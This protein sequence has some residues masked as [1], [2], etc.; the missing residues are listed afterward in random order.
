MRGKNTCPLLNDGLENYGECHGVQVNG[1]G[2]ISLVKGICNQ[3]GV[4][5]L[6]WVPELAICATI[7]F[8]LW[9]RLICLEFYIDRHFDY[10]NAPPCHASTIDKI[11][12]SNKTEPG[13]P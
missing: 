3:G 7:D 12:N 6:V 11:H 5:E 10:L 9:V 13:A 2:G 4:I 1:M 8:Y